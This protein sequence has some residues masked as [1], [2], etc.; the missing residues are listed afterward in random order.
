MN[1]SSNR[2]PLFRRRLDA[3]AAELQGVEQGTV[4]ARHRMRVASRRLR[5]L[6]PLLGLEREVTRKLNR[7]LRAVTQ[8]LGP[9]RELDVLLLVIREL[10]RDARYSPAALKRLSTAVARA[11]GKACERLA[12]RLPA[13]KLKRLV[14]K[15]NRAA[16]RVQTDDDAASRRAGA[17]GP[18]KAWM[19]ALDARIARRAARVRSTIDVAGVIYVPANM[20]E[21][22]IALKKLRYAAELSKDAGRPIA[23]DLAALKAGQDLLGRLHDLE[24]LLRWGRAVQASV[25]PSDV[26]LPRELGSL[27]LAVER[28]C[29]QLHARYMG[30]RA[31]LNALADRMGG[32]N[33]L[34]ADRR[35]A[36]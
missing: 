35:A 34:V 30:D 29:R 6:L 33:F 4:E 10:Q 7:R 25:S 2:Y 19:W 13:A 32:P 9:A 8:E 11:H 23:A 17:G 14:E 15:L 21:V 22:R 26:A 20:H 28:D 18:T 12:A 5:E 24:V 27:V 1:P 16:K 31:K 3:F 36:G